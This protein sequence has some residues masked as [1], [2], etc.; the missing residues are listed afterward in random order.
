MMISPFT[1]RAGMTYRYGEFFPP[2]LSP[3]EYNDTFAHMFHPLTRE[4]TLAAGLHWVDDLASEYKTTK[5]PGDLPDHIHDVDDKILNDI[6]QC[7]TCPR[8]YRI[9]KQEL[10]FLQK[11][12]FPLPR[13]CPF[14]RIEEKIKRWVWQMTLIERSCDKCG[15]SF[16]TNYRKEDAPVVYC[17]ECYR[18]EFF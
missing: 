8:G 9:T 6:I 15:K 5:Q 12:N 4:S 11:H 17:K 13:Q 16:R 3:H 7:G 10:R 1:D 2:E 14:C 18:A